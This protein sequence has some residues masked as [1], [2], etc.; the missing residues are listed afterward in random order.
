VQTGF[1]RTGKPFCWQHEG[2]KPDVLIVGKALGGGLY[3]VSAVL[4]CWEVMDV[5]KPGTHGSTFGGNPLACAIGMAALDVLK[6]EKLD[7][8][9][10]TLGDYFRK[11]LLKIKTDKIKEVRGLGLLTGLEL[12]LEAGRARPYCLTMMKLGILAKDTHEQTIR[13]APPLVITKK[14][15]DWSV[16]IIAKALETTAPDEGGG[17]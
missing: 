2:A 7:Q 1:C 3:P 11:Q 16:K 9:A 4:S 15:I 17:H 13:F 14:D 10:K 8:K 5:F 12:K 6:K